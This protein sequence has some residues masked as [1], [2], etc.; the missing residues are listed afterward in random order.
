MK[1]ADSV[2]RAGIKP[3]SLTFQ[4][5][6]LPLHNISSLT[7]PLCSRLPIYA[8]PRLRGQCRLLQYLHAG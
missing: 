5:S 1:M 6:V 4:A 7:S 3:T 2:P 8:A